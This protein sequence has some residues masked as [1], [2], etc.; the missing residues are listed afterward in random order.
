MELRST[1]GPERQRE[2]PAS[3]LDDRGRIG[4]PFPLGSRRKG[5]EKGTE[6][7]ATGSQ[8]DEVA[9]NLPEAVKIGGGNGALVAVGEPLVTRAPPC[10][11]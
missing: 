4:L 3:T 9:G 5:R 1:P 6:S 2:G 8:G 7:G 11:P 10:L